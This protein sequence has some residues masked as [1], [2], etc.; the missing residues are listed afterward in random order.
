MTGFR[1]NLERAAGRGFAHDRLGG[2]VAFGRFTLVLDYHSKQV[3]L[4]PSK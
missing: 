3:F 1:M 2:A 4:D